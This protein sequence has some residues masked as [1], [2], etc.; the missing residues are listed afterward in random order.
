MTSIRDIDTGDGTLRTRIVGRGPALLFVHGALVD[1]TLWDAVV[2]RLADRFTCVVPDLPLGSHHVALPAGADRTPAGHAARL[3]RLLDALDLRDVT[4]VGNDSGGAV[5]QLL[6]A[7]HADRVGRLVLTNCD[8]LEVFP[9]AA[10]AY[11]GWL[12][13]SPRLLAILARAL[14]AW[15]A[16]G[17]FP[18][19]YGRL[20]DAIP[21]DLL[22][23]W[24]APSLDAAV[25]ADV[26][27]FFLAARP[28]V[29]LAAADRLRGFRRPVLLAWGA[30]DPF[31][32]VDLAERLAARLPDA[33]LERF[34][35]RCY[36]AL[37]RPAEL[38]AAIARH[39]EGRVAM[40]A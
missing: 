7:D 10:F 35:A 11:L 18:L 27:G 4:V 5:A 26:A 28:E 25:R 12:A 32:R 13:H 29:T 34:D 15:P 9:P 31:F 38:A 33:R 40:S 39:A 14:N 37:D 2:A 3:A 16:L 22:R 20:A 6:C 30:R 23:G 8:A 24:L 1:G 21:D 17:R 19:A 36:V